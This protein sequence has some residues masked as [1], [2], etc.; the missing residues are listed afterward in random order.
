MRPGLLGPT[1]LES[2]QGAWHPRVAH[3][4]WVRSGAMAHAPVAWRGVADDRVTVAKW[5]CG[6]HREHPQHATQ[7]HGKV[8]GTDAQRDEGTTGRGG[9]YRCATAF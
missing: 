7:P 3:G 1:V 6:A 8:M 9:V 4:A 2:A 5:C